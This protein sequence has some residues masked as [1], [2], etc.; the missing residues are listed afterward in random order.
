MENTNK[1]RIYINGFV[2][3]KHY[4]YQKNNNSVRYVEEFEKKN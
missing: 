3:K 2:I 1:I 4:L